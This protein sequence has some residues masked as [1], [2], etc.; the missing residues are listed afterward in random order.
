VAKIEFEFLGVCLGDLGASAVTFKRMS[1][2]LLKKTR[3][4]RK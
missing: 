1:E 2:E 4:A 3:N